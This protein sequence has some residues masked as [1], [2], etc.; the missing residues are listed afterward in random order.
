[1]VEEKSPE[2]LKAERI[3]KARADLQAAYDAN[4][5]AVARFRARM[6]RLEVVARRERERF[7]LLVIGRNRPPPVTT[8]TRQRG[9]RRVVKT[10]VELASDVERVI[11]EREAG[12][13]TQAT[14]QTEAAYLRA[15]A[16]SLAQLRQN[17]TIDAGQ[18]VYAEQIRL[19]A[20]EQG[21]DVAVGIVDYEPRIATTQRGPS[22]QIIESLSEARRSVAYGLW[23]QAIPDPKGV[24]FDMLTGPVVGYTVAAKRY[25]MGNGRAKRL[26]IAAIDLWPECMD[27]AVAIVTRA[28][29]VDF[30]RRAA[31]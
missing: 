7:D 30:H 24:I 22:E 4:P 29:L 8:A 19:A 17:G 11:A 18:L 12:K 27:Q 21:A 23:R 28:S 6:A 2:Q 31:E 25:K 9:K 5:E 26:L 3:A 20:E 13:I 10:P 14:P 15:H 1:M 16:G